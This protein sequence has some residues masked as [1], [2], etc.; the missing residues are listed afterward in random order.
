MQMQS[1][2]KQLSRVSSDSLIIDSILK[3]AMEFAT[4][5]AMDKY[6]KDHPGTDKTNLKLEKSKPSDFK[7]RGP[8]NELHFVNDYEAKKALE[9]LEK[10]QKG[11]AK[12]D[13]EK[14]KMLTFVNDADRTKAIEHLKKKKL[15]KML[16]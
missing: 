4:Q 3:T 15:H 14:S 5:E 10:K 11:M 13:T 9:H 1:F 6:I 16:Y 12:R 8:K 7:G 2:P